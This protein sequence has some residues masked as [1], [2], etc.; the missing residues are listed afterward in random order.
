MGSILI[1]DDSTYTRTKIRD[2]LKA[3]GHE[4]T[5]ASDGSKGL[6][7]ISTRPPDCVILDLIMPDVDGLKIL[8][9]LHD[10]G[11]KVPVVVVTADIQESVRK[12]CMEFGAAAFISKPPKEDELRRTVKN[13]LGS[14]ETR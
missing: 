14:R 9:A 8:K 10:R 12:Q 5:E 2:F 6:H 7:A 3:D 13:I 11:D 1:I 4:I